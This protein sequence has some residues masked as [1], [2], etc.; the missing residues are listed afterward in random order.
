MRRHVVRCVVGAVAMTTAMLAARPAHAGWHAR[1]S[2]KTDGRP[3]A[4]SDIYY[5]A[6]KIRLERSEGSLIIDLRTGA[7]T[8]FSHEAKAYMVTSVADQA[9]L[10][11]EMRRQ[12]AGHGGPPAP[13][14]P[15]PIASGRTMSVGRF[16]CEVYTWKTMGSDGELCVGRKVGVDLSA[17]QHEMAT[18][19]ATLK[20]TGTAQVATAIFELACGGFPVRSVQKIHPGGITVEKQLVSIEN[21]SVPATLFLPPAGYTRQR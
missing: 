3:A 9:A 16:A 8:T 4:V 5:E 19:A 6:S 12:M 1:L 10:E 15:A 17:F 20:E 13:P 7:I 2:L 18:F 14:P 21:A 11:A